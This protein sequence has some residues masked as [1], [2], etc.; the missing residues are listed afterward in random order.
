MTFDQISENVHNR[1][2]HFPE[3]C[4]VDDVTMSHLS[5]VFDCNQIQAPIVPYMPEE[6]T[7]M[8]AH[9]LPQQQFSQ[10]HL[11]VSNLCVLCK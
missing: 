5:L 11:W 4:F 9:L 8:A 10:K 6:D 1:E 3:T 2:M 7:R